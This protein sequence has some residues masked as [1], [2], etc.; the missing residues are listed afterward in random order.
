M[1]KQTG[2]DRIVSAVSGK[3]STPKVLEENLKPL[4]GEIVTHL[5]KRTS[6]S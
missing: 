1:I 2:K 5:K 3:I 4:L 6:T